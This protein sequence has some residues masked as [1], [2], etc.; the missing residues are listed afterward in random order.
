[1]RSVIR[2]FLFTACTWF[3]IAAENAAQPKDEDDV[4]ETVARELFN[5]NDSTLQKRAAAYYLAIGEE[6]GADPTDKFLKRFKDYNPP[7][8]KR[9]AAAVSP[10]KGVTDKK[11]G[12]RGLIFRLYGVKWISTDEADLEGGWYEAGKESWINTYTLRKSN[13][14][15]KV[16]KSTGF[17]IHP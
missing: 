3:V 10:E 15:W 14:K 9:S 13:G 6:A 7:V 5:H 11:T 12:R 2:F 1:M 8:L 17:I 4:R 16:T